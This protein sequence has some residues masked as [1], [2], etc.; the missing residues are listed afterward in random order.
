[1]Q[2]HSSVSDGNRNWEYAGS[3][4]RD[5][6][7]FWF[8]CLRVWLDRDRFCRR[9]RAAPSLREDGR[10]AKGDN[11]NGRT[12]LWQCPAAGPASTRCR[13]GTCHPQDHPVRSP[14]SA[15]ARLG[16]FQGGSKPCHRPLRDI[17][18]AGPRLG[19]RRARLFRAAAA[20]SACRGLCPA[21]SFRGDPD[22]QPIPL[23][24]QRER[25]FA[26]DFPAALFPW[27]RKDDA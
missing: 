8:S 19:A 3:S 18:G 5:T 12:I 22:P 16:G 25:R 13:G 23:R 17:S 14:S 24:P 20:V 4:V 10:S 2:F 1:M 11:D 9:S 21:R 7:K 6:A 27:R 15:S 26:A